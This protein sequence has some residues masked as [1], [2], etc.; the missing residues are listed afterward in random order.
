MSTSISRPVG[1]APG[2][3]QQGFPLALAHRRR[4]GR[5]LSLLLAVAVPTA[6]MAGYLYRIADDQYVTEFR[7]SVRHQTPMHMDATQGS[8]FAAPL[9]GSAGALSVINDSQIV[10]QYLKSRQVLDDLAAAGVDFDAIYA[11]DSRDI[12][13][14]LPKGAPV[15]ERLRYW[16]RSPPSLCTGRSTLIARSR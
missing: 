11:T 7:F 8:A 12:P 4:R 14:H 13:A 6:L 1:F 2:A 15:E 10:I 9:S 3:L 16:R 5:W